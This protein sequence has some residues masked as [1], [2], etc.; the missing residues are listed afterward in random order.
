MFGQIREAYKVTK[1]EKPWIGAAM[2]FTFVAIISIGVL[3]GS[4]NDRPIY[5]AFITLP[6]ALLGSMF[7]FSFVAN[8]AAYS[9]IEGV[10]GAGASVMMA[11]RRG[12][13]T[14]PMVAVNKQQDMVHRAVGRAGIVLVGEGS[15]GVRIMLTEETKK[16]ERFVPG[17][18]VT[19]LIVGDGEGRVAINKL[20]RTMKKL[21]KEL[22]NNQ[23]REVRNRLKAVGGFNMP[24]PKGPMPKNL[25]VPKV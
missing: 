3:I 11:I 4:L 25:R 20:Q 18:P 10:M 5:A 13:T 12:Y 8:R 23:V 19:S 2:A 21:P 6:L 15:N 1:K 17:V 7:L 14:T 16:V 22:S 24:I 9:S